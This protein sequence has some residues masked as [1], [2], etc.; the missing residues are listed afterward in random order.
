MSV[1]E[2]NVTAGLLVDVLRVLA[3]HGITWADSEPRRWADAVAA[4]VGLAEAVGG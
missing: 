4:L 3:E 1:V 2:G